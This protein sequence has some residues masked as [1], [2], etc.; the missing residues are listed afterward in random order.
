MVELNVNV[1]AGGGG[2]RMDLRLNQKPGL[3]NLQV[4]FFNKVKI[5]VC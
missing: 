5:N 4:K 2:G 3:Q 1:C